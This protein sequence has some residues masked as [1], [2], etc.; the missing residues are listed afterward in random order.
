MI[1]TNRQ[2]SFISAGGP[3]TFAKR[4][5]AAESVWETRQRGLGRCAGRTEQC[6]SAGPASSSSEDFVPRPL[7]TL[8]EGDTMRAGLSG[9]PA[10]PQWTLPGPRHPSLPAPVLT[11][12]ASSS[13][14]FSVL[15][16]LLC[17]PRHKPGGLK[18]QKFILS[19]FWGLK[20]GN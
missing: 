6:G 8:L 20:V 10:P 11:F 13:P 7:W 1:M 12:F 15:G 2:N 19:Q 5:A 3:E 18:R 16:L 14:R 17:H 4:T 9:P